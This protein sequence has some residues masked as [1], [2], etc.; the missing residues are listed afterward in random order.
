MAA[1]GVPELRDIRS[2][3]EALGFG[4]MKIKE[5]VCWCKLDNKLELE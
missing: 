2:S 4:A 3:W 5:L 1:G